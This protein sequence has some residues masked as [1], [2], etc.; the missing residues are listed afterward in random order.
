MQQ[1]YK[2]VKQTVTWLFSRFDQATKQFQLT[3]RSLDSIPFSLISPTQ[4]TYLS[5]CS[6]ILSVM[7]VCVNR[8][9]ECSGK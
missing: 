4:I 3:D 7:L 8:M 1:K 6:M 5:K 9:I 2:N